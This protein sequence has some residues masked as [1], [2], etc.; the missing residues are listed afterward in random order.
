MQFR[1]R[2]TM[3]FEPKRGLAKRTLREHPLDWKT[4]K[5]QIILE[6]S[7]LLRPFRPFTMLRAGP[8]TNRRT[9]IDKF[10]ASRDGCAVVRFRTE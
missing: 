1:M 7:K 10:V 8:G 4:S 2:E 3:C 6:P 5:P 9:G